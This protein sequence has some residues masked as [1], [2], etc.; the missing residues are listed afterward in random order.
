M[1]NKTR[2]RV[3]LV[4]ACAIAVVM[5]FSAIVPAMAAPCEG[6]PATVSCD[7]QSK[8]HSFDG[9]YVTGTVIMQWLEDYACDCAANDNYWYKVIA[10]TRLNYGGAGC[11]S[12]YVLGSLKEGSTELWW[13][14]DGYDQRTV[15]V[16]SDNIGEDEK[17]CCDEP[18]V[19]Y[20]GYGL[21]AATYEEDYWWTTTEVTDWHYQ[22][23]GQGCE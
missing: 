6:L 17:Y 13:D 11:P 20:T 23:F 10:E 5:T 18:T 21:H 12:C 8:G 19:K 4:L 2:V 16:E 9:Y 7:Y 22:C 14:Y 15:I 3:S 1:I